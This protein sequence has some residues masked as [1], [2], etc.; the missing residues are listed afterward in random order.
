MTE[1][2]K[3]ALVLPFLGI[4]GCGS[5]ASKTTPDSGNNVGVGGGTGDVDAGLG[6]S[7]GGTGAG[8]NTGVGGDTG[9][10]G[11][12]GADAAVDGS[13][14]AGPVCAAPPAGGVSWWKADGDFADAIGSITGTSAG[15]V[16]FVAG[17]LGQA[18]SLDGTASSYVQMPDNAALRFT[19]PLTIDAWI[20]PTTA[21]GRIVDKIT[22][23]LAD[24]YLL[25]L[26]GGQLRMLAGADSLSSGILIPTGT[27][28]HVTG[29]FTGTAFNLYLNGVLIANK[30]ALVTA[31]PSNLL[32]FRIGADSAGNVRFTGSI[33][34]TRLFGRALSATEVQALHQPGS[35]AHCG[36]LPA[37]DGL[38]S[39]WPGDGAFTDARGANNG[40]DGG[41]VTFA[42]GAVGNGFSLNGAANSYVLV[43]NAASLQPGAALT[44]EAWIDPTSVVAERIVDKITA[45]SNNGYYLDISPNAA[46][47][48]VPLLRF[49]VGTSAIL[50]PA[51]TPLPIA[52]FT[53]VAGV[54]D[55]ATL[56]VYINGVRV[57]N[58][59]TLVTTVPT[60]TLP[61]HIGSDSAGA[62][63]FSGVIDEPRVY[64]RALAA[65]EILAIFR[66]GATS[67]CN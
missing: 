62:N 34:E 2:R 52:K 64:G 60:N 50:S 35:P 33:D 55:G 61:L 40:A 42:P 67:R 37:P 13:P 63:R 31:I 19:G 17:V 51:T 39:W 10:G 48:P 28:S 8:G 14:D 16:N 1:P 65:A 9:A 11:G 25:D 12:T 58:A 5:V 18:F 23:G 3:L 30:T 20:N 57:N 27:F 41:G 7:G 53:H 45:G 49:G 15:G 24:G 59:T 32:P 6:G 29:V 4:L 38:I 43:P 54:Y 44:I 46:V 47:V 56:S 66:A 36:C 22:T 21:A 26:L